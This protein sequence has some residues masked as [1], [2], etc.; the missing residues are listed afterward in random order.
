MSL[1]WFEF[2]LILKIVS[3]FF[4]NHWQVMFGKWWRTNLVKPRIIW[5][6]VSAKKNVFTEA[7]AQRC[8]VK[9]GVFRNFAKI[10]GKHL[11]QSLLFNNCNFIKKEA[12][13]QVF[14]CEFCKIFESTF[15]HRTPLVA[16]SVLKTLFYTY[17]L[18]KLHSLDIIPEK[19]WGNI[20]WV[21]KT[22]VKIRTIYISVRCIRC[23]PNATEFY[24]I[25]PVTL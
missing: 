22:S 16:A 25:Y 12:L 24:Y 1:R 21:V 2:E 3:F 7:V 6:T 15:F 10:T 14:S 18:L 5:V 11:C 17:F 20:E 4:N 23:I 13:A 9:K 8:S 19:T